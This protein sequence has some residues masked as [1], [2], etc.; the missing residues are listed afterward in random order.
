[1]DFG[2]S[3]EGEDQMYDLI[4]EGT[5]GDGFEFLNESGEGMETKPTDEGLTKP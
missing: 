5:A 4:Q 1:M 3:R 2:A